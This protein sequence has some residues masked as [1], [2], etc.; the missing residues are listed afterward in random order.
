MDQRGSCRAVRLEVIQSMSF[1]VDNDMSTRVGGRKRR[2]ERTYER[3]NEQQQST[4]TMAVLT[5][6]MRKTELDECGVLHE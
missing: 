5:V 4:S 1:Q 6:W 2:Y 3:S